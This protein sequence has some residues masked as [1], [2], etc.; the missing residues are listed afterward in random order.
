VLLVIA[1]SR[2]ARQTLRNVCRAHGDTVVRQAGR[3]ALLAETEFGA[4]QALRLRAKHGVQ[5]QVERTEPFNE[6]EA[7][8]EDVREAARAYEARDEPATPYTAFASGRDLPSEAE[9]R[10]REL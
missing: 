3:V 4:F 9:M 10:D 1:Y 2:E 7:V 8:R 5:I 6:F